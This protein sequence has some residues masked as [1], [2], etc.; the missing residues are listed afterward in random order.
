MSDS[1]VIFKRSKSKPSQRRQ[2]SQDADDIAETPEHTS[3]GAESPLTLVSRLKNKNKKAKATSRLSFG[4][5]N[6]VRVLS[7]IENVS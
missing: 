2:K 4:G 6:E 1:P 3:N 5:D 7:V